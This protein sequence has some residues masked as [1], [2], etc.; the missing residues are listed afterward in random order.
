MIRVALSIVLLPTA[1]L[2]GAARPS[3][4]P[5]TTA[6]DWRAVATRADLRRVR[7]WRDAFVQGLAEAKAGGS[8]AALVSEGVLLD[9]DAALD[10][11]AISA[12]RYRCRTLKLGAGGNAGLAYVAYP[13]F[14]CQVASRGALS[15]LTKTGGS[16][17]PT[18]QL[19]PGG[20]RRQIFLGTLV[21]G[22]ENRA[23]AYGRD[24]QRD[25]AGALE[26]IGPQRWRLL[27]PYP[28]FES[29]LDV[30]ELVPAR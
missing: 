15:T 20:A 27:F 19:Y 3:N 7:D 12:G 10:A 24:P 26:R 1:L 29:T 5:A 13:A 9:P 6:P 17:R 21:L 18:G 8:T 16:Q 23:L 11:P 22:D 4:Q 25:M 28:R 2:A 14:D 30:I